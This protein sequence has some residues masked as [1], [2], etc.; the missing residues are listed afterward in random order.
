MRTHQQLE[1]VLEQ[2]AQWEKAMENG[3]PRALAAFT[4]K[5]IVSRSATGR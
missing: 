1:A 5:R 2:K 4:G 3:D